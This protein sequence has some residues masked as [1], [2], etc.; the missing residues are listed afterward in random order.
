MCV[1]DTFA[2]FTEIKSKMKAE[3]T[4]KSIILSGYKFALY[5]LDT[6]RF[7]EKLN[8][9]NNDKCKG[10]YVFTY[11]YRQAIISKPNFT[12]KMSH[13]LLYL[14]KAESIEVRALSPS[15]EK[16]ADLKSDGCN[17]IGVYYCKDNENP[18][19]I[20][21]II[22]SNYNFK[23]NSAENKNNTEDISIVEEV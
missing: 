8:L 13:N 7:D 11:A 9:T 2:I 10:V 21:S 6:F 18:K 15:H 16:W 5:N 22:L 12:Y 17:R 19:N 3:P 20:E 14:G 4:H 23:E 1:F